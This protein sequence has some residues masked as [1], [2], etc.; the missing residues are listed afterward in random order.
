MKRAALLLL[1][2]TQGCLEGDP[3]PYDQTTTT[4][5]SGPVAIAPGNTCSQ[6]SGAPVTLTLNN[7][8]ARQLRLLWVDYSC[9]EQPV[10]LLDPGQSFT[11][12]TESQNPWRLRDLS[13][14]ALVFEYTTNGTPLQSVDINVP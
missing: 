7:R 11:A 13:T 1:I 5:G 14:N 2:S 3:N 12:S 10:R 6:R 8:S 4:G 9:V